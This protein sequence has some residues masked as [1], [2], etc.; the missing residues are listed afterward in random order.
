MPDT[1]AADLLPPG[2]AS[3]DRA[4]L[5]LGKAPLRFRGRIRAL[6]ASA[7]GGSLASDELERRLLEMGFVEGA[8]VEIRHQGLFRRDPIAVRVDAST[9]A[10]RRREANAVLVEPL[11]EAA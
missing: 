1:I 4:S 5:P 3:Q 9:I 2:P 6:D 7:V 11:D 8:T 10:L